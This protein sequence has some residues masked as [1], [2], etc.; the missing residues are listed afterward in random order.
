MEKEL[1]PKLTRIIAGGRRE[2]TRFHANAILAIH[3]LLAL[4]EERSEPMGCVLDKLRLEISDLRRAAEVAAEN[5]SKEDKTSITDGGSLLSVETSR[6][7]RLCLLEARLAGKD[8]ADDIHLLLA[9]LHDS[10]N[11][12][13][14]LMNSL[15]ITYEKVMAALGKQ[16]NTHAGYGFGS[17]DEPD[18]FPTTGKDKTAG[19]PNSETFAKT[20]TASPDTP[21]I[22]NFG[23]DLTQKAEE[24][25]LDPVIG[26][27][28]EILRLAQILCR[29][30]K[31]NPVLI[32]QPG[33]GKSA[34]VEGLARL[35]AARKAPRPLCGKRIVAL[36]MTAIVAGTQY[37]GQ[38]EERLR[39]L[40][41]E[42]K[43]HRE[44]ILFVDELHTIVG[45]GSAPGTMDAANILKPAL[46]RG[47]MQC[48][49]A[50]TMDEYRKSIEKDGALERRFQ[51][52][53]VEAPTAEETL[54]ILQGVK[55]RYED[56]HNVRFTEDAIEACVSLTER[57]V[58]NRALPDKAIDALDEAGSHAGLKAA[59]PPTEIKEKEEII[60]RLKQEKTDAARAQNYEEAARLRDLLLQNEKELA[61]MESEWRESRTDSRTEITADNIAEVVALMSGIPVSRLQQDERLRL[62]GLEAELREKVIAQDEAVKRISKS[63][64]RNRLGL[65]SPDRP[66]GTFLFV[67]PTGVG[68]THLVKTL[69][70]YLFGRTDA[71]IRIDMSEYSEKH[72]SSR[73]LGA[74]P[75]YVG[76]D[77]GGQLTEKVRR[78]PYSIVL[79]DEIEKAHSEVFNMLLQVMDEGRLTDGNGTTVDFRNTIIVMTSNS[80]SRQIQDHGAGIGFGKQQGRPDAQMQQ[81][82]VMK[83][84]QRQFAPEFLNRLDEIIMFDALGEEGIKKIA[85]LEIAAIAERIAAGGHALQLTPQAEDFIAKKGYDE[86][87][88]ARAL[89]RTLQTYLEDLV[90][91]AMMDESISGSDIRVDVA[92]DGEKLCISPQS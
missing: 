6:I 71:L 7:L 18:E 58:T 24:G 63:I 90:C 42:L 3:L 32:G 84:L 10:K 44:I 22:D 37:R 55:E 79:L 88:G 92:P 52:I 53:I 61:L 85:R 1:S 15:G 4:I 11:S 91:D 56:Y 31:N 50:T 38:F 34:V 75:G 43:E 47:E 82:I 13:K 57:Y 19:A 36:D 70:Q 21:M 45:A 89:K 27:E 54:R 83:A 30:G 39:R 80:G 8:M 68:K 14:T 20:K 26:R 40:M 46:A 28:N 74:P 35:I 78:H 51:K 41:Q 65:K 87:Y 33:V 67:G 64:I 23:V 76:Y 86:K 48:I 81:S 73:L 9:I 2:A 60:A 49:G 62:K 29:R 72:T 12:G 66:I 69:A 25:V 77:E 16:L 5:L 17:V 59:G